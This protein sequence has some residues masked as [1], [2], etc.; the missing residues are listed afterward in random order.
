MGVRYPTLVRLVLEWDFVF[1]LV[2]SNSILFPI[3]LHVL[4]VSCGKPDFR[5]LETAL[6]STGGLTVQVTKSKREA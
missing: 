5:M 2:L 4:F 6:E 1:P 3:S